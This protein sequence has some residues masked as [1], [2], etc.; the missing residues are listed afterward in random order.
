MNAILREQNRG[1]LAELCQRSVLEINY[2][3]V[4]L[5]AAAQPTNCQSS[6]ARVAQ[7]GARRRAVPSGLAR[8]TVLLHDD[9]HT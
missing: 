7:N 1:E 4:F 5:Q 3:T 8:S 6:Q 2:I 9:R